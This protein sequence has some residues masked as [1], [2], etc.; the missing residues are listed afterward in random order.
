M[1]KQELLKLFSSIKS[2]LLLILCLVLAMCT[3]LFSNTLA[4]EVRAQSEPATIPDMQ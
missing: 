3:L 2:D 4:Q 1:L